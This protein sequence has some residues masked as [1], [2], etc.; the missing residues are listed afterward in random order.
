MH[1]AIVISAEDIAGLNIK[2]HLLAGYPFKM[3][4]ASFDGFPVFET[5]T[6]QHHVT[7]YTI[8]E[9]A[10]Y[11][12]QLDKQLPPCD[13]IIFATKHRSK[14]G[15]PALTVHSPGNWGEALLGGQPNKVNVPMPRFLRMGFEQQ[16]KQ[17]AGT[18][19]EVAMECT[20]HG[21]SIEKPCMFI[22]LGSTEEQW[23]NE[24]GGKRVAAALMELLSTDIPDYDIAFG[25]GGPHYCPNFVK[26]MKET[27][28]CFGHI[29]PKWGLASLT[30]EL[31]LEVMEKS[32]ATM[33]ILDWKGLGDQKERIVKM[34]D[35]LKI[36]WKRCDDIRK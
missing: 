8:K 19:Y 6:S 25:I 36:L 14:E 28:Y 3:T 34:L 23:K 11:C 24:D 1:I 2:H 15:V 31:V 10:I 26:V 20:H 18:H 5:K 7:L 21:P 22:E 30:K 27:N 32:G 16:E 29:C 13:A 33:V 12:E 35:E 9:A 17:A 4:A